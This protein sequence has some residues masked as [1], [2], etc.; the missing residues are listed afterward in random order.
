MRSGGDAMAK[1]AVPKTWSDLP[2]DVQRRYADVRDIAEEYPAYLAYVAEF[3]ERLKADY[4]RAVPRIVAQMNADDARAGR[5][6]P[7]KR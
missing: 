4:D 1:R 6:A 7:R 2:P 5:P 3:T